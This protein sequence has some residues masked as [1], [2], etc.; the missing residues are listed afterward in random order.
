MMILGL[1]ANWWMYKTM[2]MRIMLYEAC[3]SKEIM[4]YASDNSLFY[5]GKVCRCRLVKDNYPQET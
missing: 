5:I 1:K 3:P 2:Y 4:A